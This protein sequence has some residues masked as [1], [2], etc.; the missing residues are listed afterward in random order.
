[1]RRVLD[2]TKETVAVQC[3]QIVGQNR[4]LWPLKD[5]TAE[6][7][8][9][10]ILCR[11]IATSNGCDERLYGASACNCETEHVVVGSKGCRGSCLAA[12]L[13]FRLH[14]WFF[15]CLPNYPLTCP[16]DHRHIHPLAYC[17]SI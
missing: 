16:T 8:L 10:L 12:C 9:Q 11:H 6:Y 15:A 13:S 2:V 17:G 7:E 5:D 14:I 1:M 3:V 4:F